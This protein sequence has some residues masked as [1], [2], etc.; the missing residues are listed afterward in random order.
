MQKARISKKNSVGKIQ[1]VKVNPKYSMKGQDYEIRIDD[2]GVIFEEDMMLRNLRSQQILPLANGHHGGSD[3]DFRVIKKS[4]SF[5]DFS[6]NLL[7]SNSSKFTYVVEGNKTDFSIV[8][9]KNDGNE[10]CQSEL[11][12]LDPMRNKLL[13]AEGQRSLYLKKF[14]EQH[15]RSLC[16]N[17]RYFEKEYY[18]SESQRLAQQLEINRLNDLVNR[19]RLLQQISLN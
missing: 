12:I 15:E 17:C 3:E 5:G 9:P 19:M 4:A 6:A 13:S 14:G 1:T 2:G 10:L 8:A 16:P 11:D 18:L 7:K